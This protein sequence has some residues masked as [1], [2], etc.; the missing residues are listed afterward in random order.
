MDTVRLKLLPKL[1]K[2]ELYFK[3]KRIHMH[4]H[5]DDEYLST[6]VVEIAQQSKK[7]RTSFSQT[8]EIWQL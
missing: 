5:V 3:G 7:C 2:V 4:V 1:H 6:E 8:I